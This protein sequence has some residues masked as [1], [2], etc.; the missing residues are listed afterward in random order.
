[1]IQSKEEWE[2]LLPQNLTPE[3]LNETYSAYFFGCYPN[4]TDT[5]VD[6]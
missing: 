3:L 6:N 1:M 2:K 5:P 4:M